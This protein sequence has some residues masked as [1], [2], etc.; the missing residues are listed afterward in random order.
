MRR[1]VAL[2]PPRGVLGQ[3]TAS[4]T[5]G[6]SQGQPVLDIKEDENKE[7]VGGLEALRSVFCSSCRA[8]VCPDCF[9][10]TKNKQVRKPDV[11]MC[12]FTVH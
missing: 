11:D 12:E 2:K 7:S 1:A 4:L 10:P 8:S 6:A 9:K 3:D 5:L